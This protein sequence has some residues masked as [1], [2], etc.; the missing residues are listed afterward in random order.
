MKILMIAHRLPYPPD[1]G[2]K[3]RSFHELKYLAARHDVWCACLIDDPDDYGHADALRRYCKD[4]AVCPLQRSWAVV[5]GVVSLICGGTITEGYFSSRRLGIVVRRWSREIGFDAVLSFSSSIARYGLCVE[6]PRRIL[7]LCD[8]DS[9]KWASYARRARW[10]TRVLFAAESRRLAR[11]EW[12]LAG[13]Y[14]AAAV[15]AEREVKLF[16]AMGK[17]SGAA[18]AAATRPRIIVVRNGID[19]EPFTPIAPPPAEPVVGF[20][21]TMDYPPNVEAVVWFAERV[22]PKIRT[23]RPNA[24]FRIVGRSPSRRVRALG[25]L[26]GVEVTGAVADVPSELRGMRVVV[27]PL[28]MVH[29]VQNKVLEA[30][31]AARAAVVTSGV[32]ESIGA[33]AGMDL[34]VADE[35][36]EFGDCVSQ[37][38]DS[39]DITSRIGYAGREFVERRFRWEDEVG[40]LEQEM[41]LEEASVGTLGS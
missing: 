37:L 2:E 14:D 24:R 39:Q 13:T 36:V 17:A 33:R 35:P 21:G 3:I 7:D 25:S 31:A 28:Q 23:S 29:G 38:I 12:R 15:I 6:A 20:V 10:L 30:L 16:D 27:V 40:K 1:K 26:D 32:A 11:R 41:V 9:A 22:W 18:E 19:L 4:V 5:R 34:L 8:V